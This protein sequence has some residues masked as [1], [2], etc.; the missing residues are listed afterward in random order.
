M[1]RNAI[2]GVA[3]VVMFAGLGAAYVDLSRDF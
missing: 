1:N 2:T 3:F